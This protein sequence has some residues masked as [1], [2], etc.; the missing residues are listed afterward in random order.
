[1]ADSWLVF[2][3]M[4]ENNFHKEN[5]NDFSG[6]TKVWNVYPK[7]KLSDKK[8][9]TIAFVIWVETILW[10]NRPTPDRVVIIK[11]VDKPLSTEQNPD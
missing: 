5:E 9:T 11:G 8:H 2:F 1:M 4:V 6:L 10:T 7:N 3:K